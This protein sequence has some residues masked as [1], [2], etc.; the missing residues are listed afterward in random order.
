MH[1]IDSKATYHLTF[2]SLRIRVQPHAHEALVLLF[3]FL[4]KESQ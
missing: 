4:A 2:L 3:P 1:V